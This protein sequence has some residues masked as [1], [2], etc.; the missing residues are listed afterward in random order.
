MPVTPAEFDAVIKKEIADNKALVKEIGGELSFLAGEN[1]RGTR[2]TLT[3][4]CA[5][6][7]IVPGMLPIGRF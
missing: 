4:C 2:V 3:F 6:P 5:N 7:G 1:G